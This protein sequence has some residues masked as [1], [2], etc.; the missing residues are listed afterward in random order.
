[1]LLNLVQVFWQLRSTKIFLQLLNHLRGHCVMEE[2][3]INISLRVDLAN[4]LTCLSTPA[5]KPTA[6]TRMQQYSCFSP[7]PW[8]LEC[9]APLNR[10]RWYSKTHHKFHATLHSRGRLFQVAANVN[11]AG[12]LASSF[13]CQGFQAFRFTT[14]PDWFGLKMVAVQARHD[15]TPGKIFSPDFRLWHRQFSKF[16][17]SLES[18]HVRS[19]QVNY[20][21]IL[22]S[23]FGL[24]QSPPPA[25][26]IV[27]ARVVI[28]A[29]A[30]SSHISGYYRHWRC[31]CSIWTAQLY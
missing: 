12:G 2:F 10:T 19:Q 7:K 18:S 21:T 15:C 13:R 31:L 11:S 29:T 25:P 1:M 17:I 16:Q 6:R 5:S 9:G 20:I 27:A 3:L 22:T 26:A 14:R 28:Y 23:G 24:C 30:N 8:V 4:G